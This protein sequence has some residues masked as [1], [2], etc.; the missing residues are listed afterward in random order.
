[1]TRRP[2]NAT[3]GA[4]TLARL[5]EASEA[6]LTIYEAAERAR[7]KVSTARGYSYEHGI[8]FPRIEKL[9]LRIESEKPATDRERAMAALYQ[10][11]MTLEEIGTQYGI[12]RERVRQ[13]ISRVGIP[14]SNGG[15]SK[16]A[17]QKRARIISEKNQISLAER[18]CTQDEWRMLRDMG[19]QMMK[20]GATRSRTPIG[21]FACQRKHARR[22]KIEWKLTLWQWW[23]IWRDSGKFEHRGRG[24]GYCMCRRGD[25]GGY[26]LGNVFIGTARQN[27]SDGNKKSNLPMGVHAD[28]RNKKKPF[29]A[30]A[31]INGELQCL[32][33]FE[34]P[35]LAHAAYLSA[36]EAAR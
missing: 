22:R 13:L 34:S 12:T 24:S 23:C 25:Q 32:G 31:R 19:R 27:S 17:E 1:M 4:P 26:E 16:K 11:G 7:I 3:K 5:R 21:A 8:I 29:K 33:S 15:Q 2:Y 36:I 30:Q 20:D 35:W 14:R 10:S 28:P 18:G 6:G 9:K